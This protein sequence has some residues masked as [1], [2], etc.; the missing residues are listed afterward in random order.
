MN[1]NQNQG[2]TTFIFTARKVKSWSVP[3]FGGRC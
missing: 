1:H 3:D 2:Q